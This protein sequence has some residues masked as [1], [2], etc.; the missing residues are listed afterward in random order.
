M[1]E[2][3]SQQKCLSYFRCD[4]TVQSHK[5]SASLNVKIHETGGKVFSH[6]LR[7]KLYNKV[8]YDCVIYDY[9]IYVDIL[10]WFMSTFSMIKPSRP[11]RLRPFKINWN[12]ELVPQDKKSNICPK[13]CKNLKTFRPSALSQFYVIS[14][15]F[16]RIHPLMWK[17]F[18]G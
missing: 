15:G 14:T 9:M 8:I 5:V 2:R 17:H 12:G 13:I 18:H 16:G 11:F 3:P 1:H 4:L 10:V 6:V 7:V